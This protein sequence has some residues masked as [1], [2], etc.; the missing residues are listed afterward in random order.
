VRLCAAVLVLL[1]QLPV[2]VRATT[3]VREQTV[4]PIQQGDAAQHVE[5]LAGPQEQ[6]VE[7]LDENGLQ[8]VAGGTTGPVKRAATTVA[9]VTIGV[10]SA[11]LSVGFMLASL[12]F[13]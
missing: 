2:A 13:F 8:R 10:M 4:T 3:E 5:P 11:A 1:F 6:H 9:K 12:L 7:A